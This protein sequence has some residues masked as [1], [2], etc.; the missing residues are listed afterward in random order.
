MGS[1]SKSLARGYV[2]PANINPLARLQGYVVTEGPLFKARGL[3]KSDA[4]NPTL[5]AGEWAFQDGDRVPLSRN[6]C[7]WLR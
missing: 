7:V 1:L 3:L 2:V 4:V 6:R 5:L